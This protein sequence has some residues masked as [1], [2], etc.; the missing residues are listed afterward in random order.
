MSL[1]TYAALYLNCILL[2]NLSLLI[3]I[4]VSIAMFYLIVCF[5]LGN[6]ICSLLLRYW[7]HY[8]LVLFFVRFITLLSRLFLL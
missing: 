1:I 5:F 8:Y 7:F 6:C 3:A 4:S 2:F